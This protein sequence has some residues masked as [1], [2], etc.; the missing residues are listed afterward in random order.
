[1]LFKLSFGAAAIG[2][3]AEMLLIFF[4]YRLNRRLSA[5]EN[6]VQVCTTINIAYLTYYVAGKVESLLLCSATFRQ[7][8]KNFSC[9]VDSVCGTS[10]IIAV[11][12]MAISA[13]AFGGGM[14]ND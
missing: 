14:I 11:C 12:T 13:R 3:A 8:I 7:Y 1:M 10:V 6:V 4:L 2:L 5:E 9:I